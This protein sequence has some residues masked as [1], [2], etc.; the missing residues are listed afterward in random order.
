MFSYQM[1]NKKSIGKVQTSYIY[2]ISRKFSDVKF[3]LKL[4][5]RKVL[6]EKNTSN[7]R[8]IYFTSFEIDY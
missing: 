4:I 3:I 5:N 6:I 7:I 8:K 1:S 2:I